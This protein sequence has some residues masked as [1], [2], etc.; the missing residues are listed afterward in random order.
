MLKIL[1]PHIDDDSLS[2]YEKMDFELPNV[3]AVFKFTL[4]EYGKYYEP[5]QNKTIQERE[6][7][8][9]YLDAT[10]KKLVM[11]NILY[12]TPWQYWDD[13]L[14][15]K[16]AEYMKKYP[17]C[18]PYF[19]QNNAIGIVQDFF[20]LPLYGAEYYGKYFDT[21]FRD[22][23]S[24]EYEVTLKRAKKCLSIF[25]D[26]I[27]ELLD[28]DVNLGELTFKD[29]DG[30]CNYASMDDL[31]FW[32]E[33]ISSKFKNGYTRLDGM[34]FPQDEMMKYFSFVDLNGFLTTIVKLTKTLN[35]RRDIPFETDEIISQCTVLQKKL[36]QMMKK[37]LVQMIEESF[38]DLVAYCDIYKNDHE[39]YYYLIEVLNRI[40]EQMLEL[41]LNTSKLNSTDIKKDLDT[42]YAILHKIT[43]RKVIA[44]SPST[45]LQE[46]FDSLL[47]HL[48]FYQ[49]RHLS[50][51]DDLISR[52]AATPMLEIANTL[53]S[54]EKRLND[55]ETRVDDLENMISKY[56]VDG[57]TPKNFESM[58]KKNRK[59]ILWTILKYRTKN[60]NEKNRKKKLLQT[61][62][63][64]SLGIL[65]CTLLTSSQ[66]EPAPMNKPLLDGKP[67]ENIISI[68][69]IAK[70][71]KPKPSTIPSTST[72]S[73][74]ESI[75]QGTLPEPPS[76]DSKSVELTE[77]E[78]RLIKELVLE[79]KSGD[80]G[81]YPERKERLEAAGYNYHTIQTIINEVMIYGAPLDDELIEKCFSKNI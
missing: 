8:K 16:L 19:I 3:K 65:L 68:E 17:Y 78:I 26:I 39:T 51:M 46:W 62:K 36:N 80:W 11:H 30:S 5:H 58:I 23:F 57:T 24:N 67:I 70:I 32:N 48:S 53:R 13:D 38:D 44:T 25:I 54:H 52:S 42:L 59:K 47:D 63:I 10:D 7:Y 33:K 73:L 45:Q 18:L 61:L 76:D 31:P 27:D 15:R 2:H 40:K 55:L 77:Q 35:L 37:T 72:E 69:K 28:L 71:P 20:C 50:N 21:K 79:V 74:E 22:G 66:G 12:S 41:I 34:F 43:D 9:N 81:D 4:E 29:Y 60:E 64:G 75:E 56:I 49:L 6:Y 14:T 1:Y